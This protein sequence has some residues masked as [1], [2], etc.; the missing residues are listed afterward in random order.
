MSRVLVVD[1]EENVRAGICLFLEIDGH[2]VSM[3]G[4]VADATDLLSKEEFDVV[5]TDIVMPGPSGVDL[6]SVIRQR[7]ENTQVIVMTGEPTVDTAADSLRGGA[8]DYLSK[9]ISGK[10]LKKV[11][12]N[13]AQVKSLRDERRRLEAENRLYQEHLERLVDERTA[14]LRTT[15]LGVITAMAAALEKRD[16]YTAGHQ[17]RVAKLAQAIAAEMKVSN[18]Q[19]EGT[20]LA[21]II[22]D[23]GKIAIPAEILTKPGKLCTEEF[24]LLKKHPMQGYEIIKAIS[25]P[26]PIPE[27]VLQH[28]ERMNGSGY[29]GGLS[30]DAIKLEARILAVA[31]VME[32]MVSHRP[33]RAALGIKMALDEIVKGQDTLYD[34][35]VVNACLGLFA[36]NPNFLADIA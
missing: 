25:F 4:N 28:H 33:Y 19:I 1:D 17:L 20:Y 16:P 30:G 13:A 8:F 36:D 6:L 27:I 2:Q 15:L 35:D 24:L 9:P 10:A 34:A 23:I 31:D 21:G 12:A 18:A 29:P 14:E 3:A 22:H 26:W 5:I 7:S 32:S 11:V